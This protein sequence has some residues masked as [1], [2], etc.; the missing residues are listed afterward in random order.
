V[1]KFGATSTIEVGIG[2]LLDTWGGLDIG[3]TSICNWSRTGRVEE[4]E[5]IGSGIGAI[6]MDSDV[7]GMTWSGVGM[8]SVTRSEVGKEIKGSWGEATEGN[9][10]GRGM[11]EWEKMNRDLTQKEKWFHEKPHPLKWKFS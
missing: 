9:R 10:W 4:R 2:E 3:G 1:S 5:G 6:E 8:A 11:L 7:G